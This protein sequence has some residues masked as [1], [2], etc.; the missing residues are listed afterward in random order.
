MSW[1]VCEPGFGP[2]SHRPAR[3]AAAAAG[4]PAAG[5]Q[6]PAQ[7][8]FV[9]R[10]ARAAQPPAAKSLRLRE[11]VLAC[12]QAAAAGVVSK[13]QNRRLW[14]LISPRKTG[15]RP[16]LIAA[17]EFRP[18]TGWRAFGDVCQLAAGAEFGLWARISVISKEIRIM[19]MRKARRKRMRALSLALRPWRDRAGRP[20][21]FKSPR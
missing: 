5:H 3:R 15:V 14:R 1:P 10:P 18:V 2:A 9:C 7:P 12:C 20:P 21:T 6:V 4:R 17:T 13:Q 16:R 19:K 8:A 11:L